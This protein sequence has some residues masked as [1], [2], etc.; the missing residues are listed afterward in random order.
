MRFLALLTLMLVAAAA[1]CQQTAMGIRPQ[2][3]VQVQRDRSGAS[4]IRITVLDPDYPPSLLQQQAQ[5]VG[6][7]LGTDARGFQVS[8]TDTQT[9]Q[10]QAGILRI[11]FGVDGLT[12]PKS[13]LF[14][15]GAIVKALAGAP[16][17]YTLKQFQ[18]DFDY[19]EPPPGSLR[20][21]SSPAVQIHRAMVDRSLE[22]QVTLASQNPDQIEIPDR[23]PQEQPAKPP[24]S[25]TDATDW[26]VI[27]AVALS[28][29]AAGALVYCL[30]LT[31]P[32]HNRKRR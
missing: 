20:D 7:Y 26:I 3:I 30:L 1:F 18:I 5:A 27:I 28:A 25:R 15:I 21:F 22:Y 11:D 24:A 32:T 19:E 2:A 29:C 8:R 16:A 23:E 6:K 9:S 12:D 4:L 17:P 14:H 10:K 31:R 13:G